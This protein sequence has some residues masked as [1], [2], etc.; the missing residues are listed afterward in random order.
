[1]PVDDKTKHQADELAKAF[2]DL[3]NIENTKAR[4]DVFSIIQDG[5]DKGLNAADIL[6]EV[7]EWVKA[8]SK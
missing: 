8:A 5:H 3:I 4:L 1:M 7:L 6:C 2:S